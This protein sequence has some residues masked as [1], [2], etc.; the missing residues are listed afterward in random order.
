MKKWKKRLRF[1][2]VLFA[3][4]LMS[5]K[6]KA[7]NYKTSEM[8]VYSLAAGKKICVR[9]DVFKEVN[10]H[11]IYIWTSFNG[12]RPLADWPG[13]AMQEEAEDIYC[14]THTDDGEAYDYVIF[15]GGG[16]QTI[17][18]SLIDDSEQLISTFLYQF[19]DSH[20]IGG[21]YIGAWY[22]YDTS[23]LVEIVNTAK[24]LDGKD[25]TIASYNSVL[26]ALG[27][28][29][30]DSKAD[31]ISKATIDND[32]SDNLAI[33]YENNVYSSD[34]IDAYNSLA[35]AMNNLVER[36][37][38]VVNNSITGGALSA[39]YV[40]NSDN[41][42]LITP[43]PTTGYELKKLTVKKI[44]S[45]DSSDNPVYGDETDID[46]SGGT[47]TY[48]YSFDES[49]YGQNNMVGLYFNAQ[50]AKKTFKIRFIVGANGEI[51]TLDDGEVSSPVTVEYNDDYSIK[52]KA[53][54]GYEIDKILING[55]EYHLTDG[56]LVVKNVKEDTEV[57]I[58]F[59]LKTY[60]IKV[61]GTNYKF[62]YNTTYDQII[63]YLNLNDNE[64]F[65]YLKDKEGKK[66]TEEYKVEKND[67]LT[68]V[69]KDKKEDGKKQEENSSSKDV[70]D[71][72]LT[73]DN[74]VKSVVLSILSLNC[75][76]LIISIL[77]KRGSRKNI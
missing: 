75:V 67:E 60:N 64:D 26:A 31:Y 9:S 62:A 36:M 2:V 63:E 53:K 16:R 19:D 44:V 68:V 55:Q 32:P 24:A 18:L 38:I 52:I 66:L 43:N 54:K 47:D 40:N 34:Y 71:N 48:N 46:I 28:G 37:K 4:I 61:D 12:N 51:T 13:I 74:I 22:V 56:V 39:D 30:D 73:R 5:G 70:S 14:Y 58:S 77:L 15:N 17:D 11:N 25:Y 7:F 72:P 21:K 50:F 27:N 45:Y 41:S 20:M 29:T 42:V 76:L 3:A 23:E 49:E 6:I 10:A 57:E 59:K 35:T 1:L 65:L 8:R 33:R 69:Y